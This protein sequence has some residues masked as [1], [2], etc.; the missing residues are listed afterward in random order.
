M[1][2]NFR[3]NNQ[4]SKSLANIE[5]ETPWLLH[6]FG[7]HLFKDLIVLFRNDDCLMTVEDSR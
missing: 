1:G 6:G 7:N 2:L 5:T 3:S 4:E